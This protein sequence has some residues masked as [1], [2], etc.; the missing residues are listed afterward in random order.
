[1]RKHQWVLSQEIDLNFAAVR[2]EYSNVQN[3]IT[4]K[5]TS[6]SLQNTTQKT[7]D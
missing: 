1:M 7:K 6:N 3:K 2:P 5:M 4:D